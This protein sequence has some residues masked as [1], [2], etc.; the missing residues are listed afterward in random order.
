MDDG[1]SY[2]RRKSN[3]TKQITIT[4]CTECFTKENQQMLVDK[5][6][7]EYGFKCT[8]VVSNDGTGWRIRLPQSQTALFYDIIGKCPVPSME[9]KWK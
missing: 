1:S 9:Y 7:K 3:K 4:L 5:I 6:N 8:V 2:Q